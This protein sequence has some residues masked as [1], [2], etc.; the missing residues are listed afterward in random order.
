M[1]ELKEPLLPPRPVGIASRALFHG[2]EISGHKKRGQGVKSWIRVGTNAVSELLDADKFTI[3]RRCDLPARDLRLLDPLFDYPST[4]LGREKA[5][6]VNLEQIRC[7]ITADEVLLLNCLDTYVLQYVEE[8]QRRLSM[9]SHMGDTNMWQSRS[10]SSRHE[11]KVDVSLGTEQMRNRR[12]GANYT[13]YFSGSSADNLPFEFRALEVALE[14]A[15][16]YLDTQAADNYSCENVQK[17]LKMPYE[18]SLKCDSN[19]LRQE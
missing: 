12:G 17:Q 10:Q 18:T 4:I 7:I 19:R 5:I 3:M 8:L 16:T 15:C 13:D 1:A 6:V 11:Y 14:A 2:P 9:R